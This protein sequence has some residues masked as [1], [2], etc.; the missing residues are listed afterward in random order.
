MDDLRRPI[1]LFFAI[2]GIILIA[3]SFISGAR[4]PMTQTD[5]NLYSGLSMLVFGGVM[6]WLSRRTT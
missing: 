4:A 3:V 1:G 2:V 5:I 6:L